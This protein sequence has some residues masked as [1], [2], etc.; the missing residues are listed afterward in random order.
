MVAAVMTCAG[1]ASYEAAW[2]PH[3]AYSQQKVVMAKQTE[4]RKTARAQMNARVNDL[5]RRKTDLEDN[6]LKYPSD[7]VAVKFKDAVEK[8]YY[9]RHIMLDN[10]DD[11][12]AIEKNLAPAGHL[13]SEESFN[14]VVTNVSLDE[15]S[16]N[17]R[18]DLRWNPFVLKDAQVM[19]AFSEV[20]APTPL[21]RTRW[22]RTPSAYGY[23]VFLVE[24]VPKEDPMLAK[25]AKPVEEVTAPEITVSAKKDAPAVASAVAAIPGTDYPAYPPMEIP[26]DYNTS[27]VN[28][29]AAVPKDMA[30]KA[31]EQDKAAV[32]A[33]AV[34]PKLAAD[35]QKNTNDKA[36]TSPSEASA[37][38]P[39][40]EQVIVEQGRVLV[41]SGGKTFVVESPDKK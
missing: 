19:A 22:I 1:W 8:P 39:K 33:K 35:S 15:G 16:A 7:W 37:A 11:I 4:A 36:A 38:A 24:P 3:V 26:G 14:K 27:M 12:R 6:G 28:S 25:K 17:R 31:A 41:R 9:I 10:L 30:K 13:V 2:K 18:G 23:H 20:A 5:S 21:E 32:P 40:D 29:K 34:A